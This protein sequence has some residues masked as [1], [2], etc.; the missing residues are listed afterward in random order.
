MSWRTLSAPCA[1]GART[2]TTTPALPARTAQAAGAK[3]VPAPRLASVSLARSSTGVRCTVASASWRPK[4]TRSSYSRVRKTALGGA[5][6]WR[7]PQQD[8]LFDEGSYQWN[9]FRRRFRMP[10][11]V[12]RLVCSVL[13]LHMPAEYDIT[14]RPGVPLELKVLGYLRVL[15]RGWYF[16]DV[17]EATGIPLR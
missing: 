3:R 7:M 1:N 8:G 6:W 2:R 12:F 9:L 11:C 17:A 14:G 5:T 16:D 4:R 10:P 15:G 13:K